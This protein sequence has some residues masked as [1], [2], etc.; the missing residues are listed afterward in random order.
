[1]Y[2]KLFKN[3]HDFCDEW[4]ILWSQDEFYKLEG[5]GIGLQYS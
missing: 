3:F 4:W 5:E 1:M 2:S